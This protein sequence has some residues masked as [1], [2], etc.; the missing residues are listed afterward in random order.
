MFPQSKESPIQY[1][2]GA[3]ISLYQ[4]TDFLLFLR[5]LSLGDIYLDPALKL[6]IDK[7]GKSKIKRRN[8]FRINH[9]SLSQLYQK[10]ELINLG[11]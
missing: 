7:V 3:S 10:S 6:E 1:R 4:G 2:Y 11:S 5:G 9:K 8:Q